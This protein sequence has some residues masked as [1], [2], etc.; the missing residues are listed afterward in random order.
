M[1][2]LQGN[3]IYAIT[4]TKTGRYYVGRTSDFKRRKR[5]HFRD[6]KDGKHSSPFLQRAYN[7]HGKRCFHMAPLCHGLGYDE[8]VELEQ[9]ML[10]RYYDTLY[11]CSRNATTP[12]RPGDTHTEE[13]KHK[14]S[15]AKKGRP[16]TKEHKTALK[17][18][19]QGN[20]GKQPIV[21]CPHCGKK[22]GAWTMPRWHFDNCK[23]AP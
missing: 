4:N 16:L 12:M 7:K 11:N 18:R 8:A 6:L 14:M 17:N 3:V 23:N 5:D 20:F 19:G 13:V 15:A 22:G 10:D 1:K 9:K 21:S 2:T